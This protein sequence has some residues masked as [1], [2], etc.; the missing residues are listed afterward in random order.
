MTVS[1]PPPFNGI[2]VAA[3][4]DFY[5]DLEADNTKSFWTSHKQV[6]DQSVRAPIEELAA[7]LAPAFGPGKR[8]SPRPRRAVRQ[9]QDTVQDAPGRVVR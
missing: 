2:P 7:A 1:A 6:Y 9:G 4:L 5:E 3:A 8:V